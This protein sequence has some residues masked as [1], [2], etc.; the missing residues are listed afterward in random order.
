MLAL[1]FGALLST[2]GCSLGPRSLAHS[3]LR[4]N[5][6]VKATSEQQLLLNIVR[7]R[8]VDTPSSLAISSIADQQEFAAGLGIVPFFAA[9]GAGDVGNFSSTALPNEI[10]RAHV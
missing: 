5:E 6:T 4:Y 3:R 1:L 9:A 2:L 7:L 8:Y 10:G